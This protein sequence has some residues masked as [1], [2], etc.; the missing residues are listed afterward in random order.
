MGEHFKTYLLQ[1][2]E[3]FGEIDRKPGLFCQGIEVFYKG[4]FP[5]EQRAEFFAEKPVVRA[6][7]VQRSRCFSGIGSRNEKGGRRGA[8]DHLA[9]GPVEKKVEASDMFEIIKHQVA[10]FFTAHTVL[11]PIKLQ[12]LRKT[13]MAHQASGT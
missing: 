9:G 2:G 3:Y 11:V 4:R 1:V 10:G 5:L 13:V 8:P 12:G 7:Q 6:F